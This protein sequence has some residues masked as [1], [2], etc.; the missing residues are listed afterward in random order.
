MVRVDQKESVLLTRFDDD[1]DEDYDNRFILNLFFLWNSIIFVLLDLN[2]D[3]NIL[4]NDIRIQSEQLK[5]K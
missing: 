5:S 3:L 4:F 2:I 1:V